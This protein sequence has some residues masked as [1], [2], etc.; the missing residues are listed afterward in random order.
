MTTHSSI[1]T[2]RIPWTEEPGGIQSME[3]QRIGHDRATKRTHA[4][5][6]THTYTHTHTHT[7][8]ICYLFQFNFPWPQSWLWSMSHVEIHRGLTS[9]PSYRV[10][11]PHQADVNCLLL[12]P[13]WSVNQTYCANHVTL[14]KVPD[15]GRLTSS[16]NLL[17]LRQ[18]LTWDQRFKQSPFCLSPGLRLF[19]FPFTLPSRNISPSLP[20]WTSL[21]AQW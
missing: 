21:V 11:L 15:D 13:L 1:L 16:K 3:S 2:W 10:I 8:L 17:L 19:F 4:Q 14:P 18:T 9:L 6:H 20:F 7:Q 5:T 12:Y